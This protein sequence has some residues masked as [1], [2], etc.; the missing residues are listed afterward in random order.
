M[1]ILKVLEHVDVTWPDQQLF[2]RMLGPWLQPP[3]H[4]DNQSPSGLASP[5]P[6][7]EFPSSPEDASLKH[8]QSVRIIRSDGPR[9]VSIEDHRANQCAIY[10][11]FRA[12]LK[13]SGSQ[14]SVKPIVCPIPLNTALLMS[15]SD[16]PEVAKLLYYI[17]TV[18]VN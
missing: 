6:A 7:I 3:I 10:L 8:T 14:Q 15:L 11:T 12:G 9:L 4:A 5:G 16:R 17:E 1:N 2:S 18:G 13:S